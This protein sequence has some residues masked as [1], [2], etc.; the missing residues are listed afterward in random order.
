MQKR[1]TCIYFYG[2]WNIFFN[3]FLKNVKSTWNCHQ[4]IDMQE[5]EMHNPIINDMK[6]FKYQ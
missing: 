4:A 1:R 6:R 5:T 2:Q 3:F